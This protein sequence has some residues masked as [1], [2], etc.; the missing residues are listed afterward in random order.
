MKLP[1]IAGTL[2][3]GFA[4]IT[5]FANCQSN[6]K[7]AGAKNSSTDTTKKEVAVENTMKPVDHK[8]YD[9]LMVKL[10]N[11]DTTGRW[12]VKS[13]VYPLAGAILPFKRVVV[14]YGNLHSKKMGALG[15]YAPKEMWQ[16]LNAE[17]KHWEKA[18]PSTPVQAGLHYIAAVASGTPGK[19]GK[20]INRMANKQIDSVLA[21]AKMR[22]GTIVFLDLQVALSTIKAELPHIEKYLE[23]PYVH[24]G[25]DPEFSMKDGTLPG[26]KIG[27]YDA[28][29]VN[30]VTQYLADMVKKYNL[31]PKIF[32]V[33]RFT[34]KMV[35][36]YKN[37]KLRPEVQIVMHM[38]GWG[39]PD[40]KLGTYRHFIQGE[41][42][43]FT[44]FKL[45]YK[46]DLKKAPNRLMTPEE[47]LKLKPK[48][49]YIQYQ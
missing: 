39:E 20:Y 4:A 12:P 33:H 1:Q 18:D 14:Y 40:L 37:I 47:L 34:K 45:F 32:V 30:Y 15:E 24:L 21:I 9:S 6:G 48:P 22:P 23:L 13:N 3:L 49:I 42:V 44:G 46:N 7:G 5:L 38:D 25:I 31:P 29:D 11:G 43:Q 19:D 28:A 10:A 26:K 35:T 2:I 41:P 8:L 17:I 27:T 16:R 36:N